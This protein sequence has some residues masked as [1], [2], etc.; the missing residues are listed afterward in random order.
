MKSD[1][2]KKIMDDVHKLLSKKNYTLFR[3][4]VG[5][6]SNSYGTK[7]KYGLCKGS[8]DLIGYKI[9]TVNENDFGKKIAIFCAFEIKTEKGEVREN[10]NDFINTLNNNGGIAHVIRSNSEAEKLPDSE[11]PIIT[12]EWKNGRKRMGNVQS[13]KE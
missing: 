1:K 4:N 7:V 6:L 2:E 9:H 3:N 13:K 12:T 5:M 10:Q 11:C 8:S